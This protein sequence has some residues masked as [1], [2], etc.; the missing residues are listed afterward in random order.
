[1]APKFTDE[2]NPYIPYIPLKTDEIITPIP[3]NQAE[4]AEILAEMKE[5]GE[6]KEF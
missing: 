5:K 3:E 1:M 6:E 2:D 4:T